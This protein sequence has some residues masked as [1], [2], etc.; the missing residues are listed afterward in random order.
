MTAGTAYVVSYYSASGDYAFQ[1]GFFQSA[2]EGSPLTAPADAAGSPNGVFRYGAGFP[3]QTFQASNYWAD[4]VF[5]PAD[6]TAP[7]VESVIP[8]SDA[9]GVARDTVVAVMFSEPL[10]PASLTSSTFR[11][12]D[13]NGTVIPA[14]VSYDAATRTARLTPTT[15]LAYST[16][17]TATVSAV[18]D[19]A[20]NVLAGTRTWSFTTVAAPAGGGP[21]GDPPGSGGSPATDVTAPRVTVGPKRARASRSGRVALRIRCPRGE[22]RCSVRLQLKSGRR[23]LASAT[24]HGGR[25][26]HPDGSRPPHRGG[27]AH[28]WPAS[29]PACQRSGEGHGC[30]R[31][32]RHAPD[33][34]RDPSPTPAMKAPALMD[35]PKRTRTEMLRHI[36]RRATVALIAATALTAGPAAGAWAAPPGQG[37]GG[38][39]LV[40]T[41]P[42]DRFGA[43]Y[44][45]ILAAEGLNEFAVTDVS[46]LTEQTLA[47]HQVVVLARDDAEPGPADGAD[48]LGAGR[49][50]PRGHAAG[51]RSSRG[52]S[53][54]GSDAGDLSD[55]Y[56]GVDTSAAPG[57]G[58][59]GATMQFHGTA[60]R[61][62]PGGASAG[63]DAVQRRRRRRRPIRR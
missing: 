13:A 62:T 50:Q 43:Y 32:S 35:D 30:R 6:T 51:R 7:T 23:T 8:A 42:G 63:R 40:V 26:A 61:W 53:G 58:I 10:D 15:A 36:L 54:L 14:A 9:A 25:R 24:L 1:Q 49:R 16:R 31:Q 27:A 48:R 56:M 29:V 57:R 22:V 3:T 44:A 2:Y 19:L 39:I 34:D 12:R 5:V 28:P 41:D 60:D 4:V 46:Q 21:G 17:Y 45:E 38:P 20:G 37:P 47:Q 59:T 55:A 52:C 11:L 18:R 33:R